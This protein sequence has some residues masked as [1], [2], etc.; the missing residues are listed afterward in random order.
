METRGFIRD[1]ILR[2]TEERGMGMV[3]LQRDPG[4]DTARMRPEANVLRGLTCCIPIDFHC[5][6]SFFPVRSCEAAAAG[7]GCR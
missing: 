3:I 6:M 2:I 4:V 7:E 5:Q 1:G